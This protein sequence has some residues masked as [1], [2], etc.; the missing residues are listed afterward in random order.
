MKF[1]IELLVLFVL[2]YVVRKGLR[3][4][5]PVSKIPIELSKE[6]KRAFKVFYRRYIFIYAITSVSATVV[7]YFILRWFYNFIHNNERFDLYYAID[8]FS[9]FL[10]SLIGG[11]LIATYLAEK[12][13]NRMQPEGLAF[14]LLDLQNNW[15][16]FNRRKVKIGHFIIVLLFEAF[17]IYNQ[18][19]VFFRVQ[20]GD[21]QYATSAVYSFERRVK[22]VKI[23]T[24]ADPP[25]MLF[26]GGDTL[27]MGNFDYNREQLFKK[28]G[29]KK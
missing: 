26:K 23:L 8:N 4:Y 29:K 22:D 9:L 12:I 19:Q 18:S 16:G 6:T 15:E 7:L 27:S 28:F 5:F 11:F 3:Q 1:A 21:I 24:E 25:L 17:L 14:F 13:N 10:P 20:N 2:F